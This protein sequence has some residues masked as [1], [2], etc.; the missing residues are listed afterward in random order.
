MDHRPNPALD[1]DETAQAE[2][3]TAPPARVLHAVLVEQGEEELKRP[4]GSLFFSGLA[5]GLA[6]HLSIIAQAALHAA[7]P[8]TPWRGV[9]SDFGYSFGF[10][11]LILG[12]LQLFTESTVTAVLPLVKRPTLAA[13]G[14]TLRLWSIV[15]IANLIGTFLAALLAVHGVIATPEQLSAMLDLSAAI[16][17]H[18][19]VTNIGLA[20]P[21]GF[22]IASIPWVLIGARES[23]FW[24]IIAVT[25]GIALGDFG[26][27]VVGSDEAFL[28]LL[29]GHATPGQVAAF[30]LP[31]LLGNIIGGSGLF[32]LL[33]HGQVKDEI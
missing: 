12:R 5:A 14:R 24:V 30:L 22:L 1:D 17:K 6:I 23:A 26:H 9:V 11:I 7:L 31:T 13:F 29:A 19:A 10:V 2:D 4:I 32:A 16:L 21:A 27:V 20:I 33:A 15:L 28:L 25:Y 8:N 18:D 3:R